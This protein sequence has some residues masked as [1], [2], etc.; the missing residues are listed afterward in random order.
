M[1]SKSSDSSSAAN[2][3]EYEIV[4]SQKSEDPKMEGDE[5]AV[6]ARL[7]E[8]L[9]DPQDLDTS[10]VNENRDVLEDENNHTIFHN[11]SYLGASRM[12]E[13]KNERLI[14]GIIKQYNVLDDLQQVKLAID[15]YCLK[16]GR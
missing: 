7:S 13:P 3:E 12:T 14:Q 16:I 10:L 5:A 15:I 11:I 6:K 9:N 8:C 4:A 2:S 1:E